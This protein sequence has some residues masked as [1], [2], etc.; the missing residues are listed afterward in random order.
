VCELMDE[1]FISKNANPR[2]NAPVAPFKNESL[3]SIAK[4]PLLW[5]VSMRLEKRQ[6]RRISASIF[7]ILFLVFSYHEISLFPRY[8]SFRDTS[9]INF[10]EQVQREGP[11]KAALERTLWQPPV[12]LSKSCSSYKR[13]LRCTRGQPA[14]SQNPIEIYDI[15]L[16]SFEVD[17]L[18]I[19]FHE[20][21]E[22]VSHFVIVESNIDHKG[23]PK[24]LLWNMLKHDPRFVPFRSKVIHVVRDVPLDS[25]QGNRS[26]IEWKF[27]QQSWEKALEFC[28]FLP[29]QAIVMLGFVDEIVSRQA[30]YDA[31]YCEDHSPGSNITSA[32]PLSFGIW[33]PFG[34]LERAFRTDWP[35]QG[36][37]YTYGYPS[38]RY[39]SQCSSGTFRQQFARYKLG[40]LHISNYCFPPFVILKELTGTEYGS[41]SLQNM[42]KEQC[43]QLVSHCQGQSF[44]RTV[45]LDQ[46]PEEDL[47][48]VYIPWFVKCNPKRYPSLMHEVDLRAVVF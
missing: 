3:I 16:F 20:L 40:G 15:F 35:I 14:S 23:Y 8:F 47:D 22:L 29:P 33:F 45:P 7:L 32:L 46:V 2:K 4:Q 34:H 13:D 26:A 9:Q 11:M 17:A 36:H 28:R 1:L 44:K 41:E 19:R 31:I 10:C 5:F 38:L 12:P 39:A 24:P 27:E 25:V 48:A 37:P 6:K 43:Q 30:L 18:E 21:D 42:T